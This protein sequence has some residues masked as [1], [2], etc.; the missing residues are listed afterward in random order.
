M[1]LFAL[2]ELG[3]GPNQAQP[4]PRESEH[5]PWWINCTPKLAKRPTCRD[6]L[7]K[8]EIQ[9]IRKK[10]NPRRPANQKIKKKHQTNQTTNQPQGAQ[11]DQPGFERPKKRPKDQKKK[12]NSNYKDQIK[13]KKDKKNQSKLQR[14][15]KR[16]KRPKKKKIQ[17]TRI[18]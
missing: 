7:P 8:W 2:M 13:D 15:N 5:Q 6:Q 10:I 3:A 11:K 1:L 17:I 16:S 4:A 14:S 18:K 12:T 9:K